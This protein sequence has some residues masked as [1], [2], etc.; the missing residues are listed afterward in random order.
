MIK[1]D[2]SGEHKGHRVIPSKVGKITLF[3][4][5]GRFPVNRARICDSVMAIGKFMDDVRS[6]V[7]Y[8]GSIE[9]CREIGALEY[10]TM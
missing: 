6:L 7:S 4:E 3:S 2:K 5:N 1:G 9:V 10:T 8:K